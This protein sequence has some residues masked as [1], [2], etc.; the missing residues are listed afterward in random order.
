MNQHELPPECDKCHLKW[1]KNEEESGKFH[2]VY[3]PQCNCYEKDIR[4]TIG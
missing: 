4:L 3:Q 1:E 2:E